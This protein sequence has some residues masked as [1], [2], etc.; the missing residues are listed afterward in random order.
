MPSVV[1]NSWNWTLAGFRDLVLILFSKV[2]LELFY[3][4]GVL[5]NLA[6]FTGKC[7]SH[8]GFPV[9]FARFLRTPFLQST[10]GCMLLFYKCCWLYTLQLYIANNFQVVKS[11]SPEK[12]LIHISQGFYIFRILFLFFF[13]SFSFSLTNTCLPCR[14]RKA[15]AVLWTT[16]RF[17]GSGTSWEVPKYGVFSGPYFRVFGLNTDQE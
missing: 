10:S 4:K 8:R 9:D 5:K 15:N 16:N 6:L 1:K 7:L 14:L 13:F 2:I 12:K 3:K 17:L 11:H